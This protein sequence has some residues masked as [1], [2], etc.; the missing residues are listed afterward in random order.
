MEQES[1]QQPKILI[2]D[3]QPANITA[4]QSVLEAVEAEIYTAASGNEALSQMLRHRFAAVLV[5]VQMPEMDGFE[6]VSLMRENP[7]TIYTPV[8]FLSAINKEIEHIYRGYDVGAVD[9]LAKPFDKHILLAK[10]NILLLFHEQIADLEK[11]VFYYRRFMNRYGEAGPAMESSDAD[12]ASS[13]EAARPKVL[14]VD[15]RE[16]N[17]LSMETILRKLPVDVVKASSGKVALELM[18]KIDVCLVL[19]DVQ[20]PD[21]DG[22]EVANVIHGMKTRH[23]IPIIFVTA[24]NKD[25]RHVSQ[26]YESGAVD[27]IFKPVDPNILVSK[28]IVFLQLYQHRAQL[29]KLLRDKTGLLYKIKKQNVQLGYM[30]YHDPLTMSSNRAGFE[31]MLERSFQA[32]KRYNRKFAILLIDLDN[33]KLINDAYGHEYGDILLQK[34]AKRL[35]SYV[36]K[37]DHVAR[38]G[39]DEF[40]VIL[41]EIKTYHD[42]G[43]VAENLVRDLSQTYAIKNKEL[44]VGV[45]IGIACFPGEGDGKNASDA[46]ELVKNADVAM[47]RAKK[48][49]RS[50]Y[51][52]FT[53]EFSRQHHSRL[54]IESSLKFAIERDELFLLYQPKIKMD[55]Q[56]VVGVEALL[57]WNH[58]EKG[59][60]SPAD[61]IPIAE[62]TQMI[63]PVGE[64][65]LR[66]SFRQLKKISDILKFPLKM[67]INISAYQLVE[68]NF[69]ESIQKLIA[70]THVPP[71]QI[72][73]EL[74]ET[75]VMDDL[76]Q[77]RALLLKLN[78][79]GFVV[80]I[81][82]F[83]TG[84]SML[85]YLKQ[86]PVQSLKIDTEFVRDLGEN[87]GSAMIVKAIIDLAKNFELEVIAEGVETQAQADFLV[88]Q[89]CS[90]A[91]G[92]LYSPPL[93]P[94]DLIAFIESHKVC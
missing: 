68:Q 60:V 79:I 7:E 65:V 70:E 91:Q 72:E 56:E 14:V 30:A 31:M 93:S 13:D 47:F 61:F 83:G 76:E 29:Q 75:A 84:Y 71:G 46:K 10:V 44:R 2:V 86:L 92:Y 11:A 64:W 37:S 6:L 19:L 53:E 85:S 15:D 55:T 17:L 18:K 3:D 34:V 82:D 81:D 12:D 73:L 32:S 78:D 88:E 66:E 77:V 67:A 27:Y 40:S 80:S 48:E 1:P 45:S 87:S 74:T 62:E 25:D 4:L 89:G 94:E 9:Y 38:I 63:V 36:R 39:G 23:I 26:G 50:S 28:V 49:N 52:Y 41:D 58:S 90:L 69:I 24:I 54:V 59:L 51:E 35:E 5:D 42:A 20:M 57:R 21:M 33:F 8:I 16:E 43:T 22:F